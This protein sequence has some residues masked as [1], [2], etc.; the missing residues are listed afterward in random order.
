MAEGTGRGGSDLGRPA[1]D[2]EQAFTFYA[3]LPAE[4]RSYQAVADQFG[5]SVRTVE[6]HGRQDKWKQRLR[7]I[8]AQVAAETNNSLSQSRAEQIGKLV[9]LIDATLIAYADKLRRGDLRMSPSDLDRLH[10]LWQQLTDELAQPADPMPGTVSDAPP[11][12]SP[13]HTAE[14]IAALRVSGALEVLGLRAIDA[15]DGEAA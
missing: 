4:R 3:S 1:I 2:W 12:R 8:N 5:V 6:K 13:E 15:P 14:V 9:K 11:A 7:G 10:K